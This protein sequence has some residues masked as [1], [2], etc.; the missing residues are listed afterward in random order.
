MKALTA[1]C[2]LWAGLLTGVSFL[3]T[4]IK[5]HAPS[6]TLPVA[7]DVGRQTFGA[8]NKVE[9][10]AVALSIFL[11]LRL[12]ERA[13]RA[14]GIS[15]WSAG[16]I[17]LMQAVWLRPILDARVTQIFA[18]INPPA[19]P[20]HWIYIGLEVVKLGA[21]LIAGT[22]CLRNLQPANATQHSQARARAE[23]HI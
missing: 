16:L 2:L 7:L 4:P 19:S 12:R 5:F 15:L 13:P 11:L 22:G 8:L 1:L 17:V 18:H 21:L 10:V 6:L 9:L 14:V 23:A 3:A 20:L